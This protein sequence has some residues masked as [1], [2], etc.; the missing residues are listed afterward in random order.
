[1]PLSDDDRIFFFLSL[2]LIIHMFLNSLLQQSVRTSV[3]WTSV[4]HALISTQLPY[5]CPKQC[6]LHVKREAFSKKQMEPRG[7]SVCCGGEI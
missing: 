4:L 5:T 7:S 2:F 3:T 1:M 6:I